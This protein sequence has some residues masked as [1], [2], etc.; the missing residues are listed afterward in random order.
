M[1]GLFFV[2][3]VTHIESRHGLEVLDRVLSEPSLSTGGAYTAWGNYP[4]SEARTIVS[5]L[6]RFTHEDEQLTW[7]RFGGTFFRVLERRYPR[8]LRSQETPFAFFRDLELR[9]FTRISEVFP[10]AEFPS[11]ECSA[12]YAPGDFQLFVRLCQPMPGFVEGFVG[13][14]LNYFRLPIYTI[15]HDVGPEP[16]QVL[17]LTASLVPPEATHPN[18]ELN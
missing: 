11:L 10:E 1:L 13:A 18:P 2:Q 17:R 3:L 15:W 8:Y 6:A 5:Q 12:P 16:G 14:C 7:K 9:M 4:A